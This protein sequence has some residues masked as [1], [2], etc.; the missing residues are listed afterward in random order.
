MLAEV[1]ARRDTGGDHDAECQRHQQV[2]HGY[3]RRIHRREPV[4]VERHEPVDRGETDGGAEQQQADDAEA[5]QT[6]EFRRIVGSVILPA[7][8]SLEDGRPEWPTSAGRR[9]AD[10]KE[11]RIEVQRLVLEDG[12]GGDLVRSGPHVESRDT[13]E[14]RE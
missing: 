4:R 11:L 9:S 1:G 12:I 5:L 3:Q 10:D 6:T 13:E 7:R 8:E 2:A 14:Q